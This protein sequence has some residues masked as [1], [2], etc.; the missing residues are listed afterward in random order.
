[1]SVFDSGSEYPV[2]IYGNY[3]TDDFFEENPD[4]HQ[5]YPEIAEF[6]ESDPDASKVM[7]S[8]FLLVDPNSFLFERKSLDDRKR[9]IKEDYFD[10][11]WL[12]YDQYK[13]FYL[14]EILINESI[15]TY[16]KLKEQ[17]DLAVDKVSGDI[18]AMNLKK[19]IEGQQL[20]TVYKKK[21]YDTMFRVKQLVSTQGG[22]K[23]GRGSRRS[24]QKDK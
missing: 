13:K 24:R 3:A 12:K 2:W 14:K 22:E 5:L 23:P 8:I 1:M 6:R 16:I 4:F 11:D 18:S 9:K 15:V 10:C 19:K 20:L 21:C 17:Y 7:W